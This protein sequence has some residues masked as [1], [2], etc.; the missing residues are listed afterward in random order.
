MLKVGRIEWRD[1]ERVCAKRGYCM[2]TCCS[3]SCSR[4]LLS[5]DRAEDKIGEGAKI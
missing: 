3:C 4:R 1:R 2:A 5:E